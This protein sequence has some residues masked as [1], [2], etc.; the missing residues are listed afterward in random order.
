MTRV[1]HAEKKRRRVPSV[2]GLVGSL[3]LTSSKTTTKKII[4]KENHKE[5]EKRKP[6]EKHKHHELPS[7]FLSHRPHSVRQQHKDDSERP[8]SRHTA[9]NKSFRERRRKEPQ[10]RSGGSPFPSRATTTE[11]PSSMMT[12]PFP[13]PVSLDSLPATPAVQKFRESIRTE[14]DLRQARR[15]RLAHCHIST[16]PSLLSPSLTRICALDLSD[17][18]LNASH[19]LS[20]LASMPQLSNL[21]LSGNPHLGESLAFL[22]GTAPEKTTVPTPSPTTSTSSLVVLSVAHCGLRSLKGLEACGSTLKTL[23]ANDNQLILFS[24]FVKT[25]EVSEEE[26]SPHPDHRKGR[27]TGMEVERCSA[28]GNDDPTGVTVCGAPQERRWGRETYVALQSAACVEAVILSRNTSLGKLCLPSSPADTDGPLGRGKPHEPA[29]TRGT[30]RHGALHRLL[31]T[32]E[33][34]EEDRGTNDEPGERSSHQKGK[35]RPIGRKTSPN[36]KHEEPAEPALTEEER[37]L[38]WQAQETQAN[39]H[40]LSVFA[41]LLHLKK[42]SLSECGIGSLPIRFFLPRVTE[43]RLSHNALTSLHPE[44]FIARSLHLLDVSHNLLTQ[45]N[46]FRRFKYLQQL[47]LRGTPVFDMF[48]ERDAKERGYATQVVSRMPPSLK[49]ALRRLLPDLV[50]VDGVEVTE[51]DP[52]PVGTENTSPPG[53]PQ[54]EEEKDVPATE[55]EEPESINDPKEEEHHPKKTEETKKKKK[56][57]SKG[58]EKEISLA[59]PQ[60]T[61][62]TEEKA[63]RKN[64][65]SK[66][67][68]E[69]SISSLHPHPVDAE[70]DLYDVMVDISHPPTTTAGLL[71]GTSIVR[72]ERHCL[73][74]DIRSLHHTTTKQSRKEKGKKGKGELHKDLTVLRGSKAVEE[75]LKVKQGFQGGW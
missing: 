7:S 47:N 34:E 74:K 29:S 46:T 21:N 30:M 71:G 65:E 13:S 5:M 58:E 3:P 2:E 26:N 60:S 1:E 72:R 50:R 45:V 25:E 55:T 32:A 35:K 67:E 73:A 10:R 31:S 11:M 66:E 48:A 43:L 49:N 6:E 8:M 33:E 59:T 28:T 62:H 17:N 12:K 56:R 63:E 70:A 37:A 20:L 9:L 16:L 42:L 51:A 38:K 57:K 4:K 36:E 19:D 23:V 44:G 41:H 64:H 52:V 75:L 24:P 18:E 15:L 39:T 69:N 54:E 40:P 61:M 14:V 53:L 22:L 68:E 27:N